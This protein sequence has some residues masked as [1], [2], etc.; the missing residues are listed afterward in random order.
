MTTVDKWFTNVILVFAVGVIL[1]VGVAASRVRQH[2][3]TPGIERELRQ[4]VLVLEETQRS[5]DFWRN[6]ALEMRTEGV[7]SLRPVPE[8]KPRGR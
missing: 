4:C 5:A 7:D 3:H 8:G 1:A 2:T 6:Q